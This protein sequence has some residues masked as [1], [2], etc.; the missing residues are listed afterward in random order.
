[1]HSIPITAIFKITLIISLLLFQFLTCY[2][3]TPPPFPPPALPVPTP[4]TCTTI[5]IFTFDSYCKYLYTIFRMDLYQYAEDE[6][7]QCFVFGRTMPNS[8]LQLTYTCY[9]NYQQYSK[10]TAY[11]YT[12]KPV[13]QMCCR[14]PSYRTPS[15]DIQ[16]STSWSCEWEIYQEWSCCDDETFHTGNTGFLRRYWSGCG[17][18]G[19]LTGLLS[20]HAR[21]PGWQTC[22]YGDPVWNTFNLLN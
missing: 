20:A 19:A 3:K 22:R 12:Y 13:W 17:C 11:S 10:A 18:P 6:L 1:M 15:A 7:V 4:M 5:K 21:G 14:T 16:T 8:E 9:S 2:Q